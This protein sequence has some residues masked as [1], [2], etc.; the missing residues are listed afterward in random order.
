MCSTFDRNFQKT[1]ASIIRKR[2]LYFNTAEMAPF[3][4]HPGKG[5]FALADLRDVFMTSTML[6]L[7]FR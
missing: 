1:T 5:Y 4:P 3:S 7:P 6:F 2:Q